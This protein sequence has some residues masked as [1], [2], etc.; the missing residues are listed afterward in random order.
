MP[1]L[2]KTKA[3]AQQ[4]A[5]LRNIDVY[6]A[7]RRR[8]GADCNQIAASLGMGYTTLYH[9]MKKPETFRLDELQFIA[10]VLNIS[11]SRLLGEEQA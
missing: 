9:K 2:P 7:E 1:R 8:A 4:A 3:E 6:I 5:V 10:N 11:I